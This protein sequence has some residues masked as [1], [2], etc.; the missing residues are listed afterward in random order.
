MP[1]EPMSNDE[2][3]AQIQARYQSVDRSGLLDLIALVARELGHDPAS[4][5]ADGNPTGYVSTYGPKR[6]WVRGD[7]SVYVDDYG[8]YMN[9]R[10]GG[11]EMCSTHPTSQFFI[12]GPWVELVLAHLPE[13]REGRD[14]R[15]RAAEAAERERL[16]S[17]IAATK[18]AKSTGIRG[19]FVAPWGDTYSGMDL[20]NG[21]VPSEARWVEYDEDGNPTPEASRG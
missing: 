6:V 11:Q 8:R 4:R 3:A 7:V 1:T 18:P 15:K 17:M 16:L 14:R 10:V 12:A 2:I 13:A 9:V 20:E 19:Q 21:F 5:D